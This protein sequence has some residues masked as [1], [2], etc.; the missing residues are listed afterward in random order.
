MAVHCS[1]TVLKQ[2][3]GI[4]TL[5]DF[6][7]FGINVWI[8]AEKLF[9][10]I[11]CSSSSAKSIYCNLQPFTRNN[12]PDKQETSPNIW[13]PVYVSTSY[14]NYISKKGL[15]N[16]PTHLSASAG[17]SHT[18]MFQCFNTTWETT[19]MPLKGFFPNLHPLFIFIPLLAETF[20][21]YHKHL[22]LQP[23][24]RSNGWW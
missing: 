24:F 14:R 9:P 11:S 19:L 22:L 5:L 12:L 15:L 21:R 16:H 10:R 3:H 18:Y 2:S 13:T 20:L 4:R 17:F 6:F 23:N 1:S 8:S 7:C